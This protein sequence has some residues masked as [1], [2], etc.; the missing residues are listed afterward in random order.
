MPK[1]T[2]SCASSP[3]MTNRT[4]SSQREKKNGIPKKSCYHK[5]AALWWVSEESNLTGSPFIL[6]RP[7]LRS[8]FSIL[9]QHPE[10]PVG[11]IPRTPIT[12]IAI[13]TIKSRPFISNLISIPLLNFLAIVK[14]KVESSHN[15]P[16]IK[17]NILFCQIS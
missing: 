17:D 10:P 6:T 2:Q 1:N 11:T 16:Q 14:D 4:A 8:P 3:K 12:P 5:A 7:M 9:L 15:R 13:N